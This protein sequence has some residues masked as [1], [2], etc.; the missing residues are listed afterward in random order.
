MPLVLRVITLNCWA[1][2]LRWPFGSSD[3]RYRIAKIGEALL[4]QKYDVVSLEEVWSEDDFIRLQEMLK[5]AYP[6]SYYF[7][8]G[9]TGSGVCIFCRHSIVST[10]MHRYSLNG[11]A[12]HIH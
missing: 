5:V 9:F 12:H 4:E 8:S 7:H 2:P 11:F 6:F 3:S 1:L 10:L